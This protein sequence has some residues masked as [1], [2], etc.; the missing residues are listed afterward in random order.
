MTPE[1]KANFQR[2]LR[3]R[4][5]AFIGGTDAIIAI[6]EARRRGYEGS[7]WPVNPKRESLAGISCFSSVRDLPEAPDAVFLAIPALQ[8]IQTIKEL[9]KIGAGG[10]VC[11][12]AGFK[13]AGKYGAYLEKELINAAGDMAMIGPNCYGIINYLDNM[14][15]WPFAHGGYCPGY[16]AA[17]ITQSGMFSSDISMSQRS[18]PLTFMVSAGNQAVM[19]LEDFIDIFSA[20]NDTRAIG[21]HI[22]GLYD[23]QKFEEQIRA[24]PI[25]INLIGT[26][27]R[28]NMAFPC[29][30][31]V[32]GQ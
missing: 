17:I 9:S 11:Y 21:V 5:V 18:L 30:R 26:E 1:Q 25:E 19:G 12:A 2:M 6:G 8:A 14:A 28:P 16:G 13:E 29:P 7:Y 4:H 31:L 24:G 27:G 15:L 32:W 3:P 10:I 22:E 20:D 23:I